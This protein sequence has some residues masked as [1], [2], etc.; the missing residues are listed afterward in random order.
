MH[1]WRRRVVLLAGVLALVP[2]TALLA[3]GNL[4]LFVNLVLPRVISMQPERVRMRWGWAWTWDAHHVEVRDFAMWV[5]GP[6]DQW[7]LHVDHATLDVE[8]LPLL[9]RRFQADD[10]VAQGAVFR[11]RGRV[12]AP[13]VP[14]LPPPTYD[15]ART[16]Q[17]PGMTNPPARD[18]DTLY[19]PPAAPWLVA[20]DDAVVTD[21]RELWLGD[22]RFLGDAEVAGDLILL[23]AASVDL[24]GLHV[25]VNGGDLLVE[26]A[27]VVSDIAADAEVS[28]EGFDPTLSVGADVLRFLD[29]AIRLD[30]HVYDLATMGI[31][32]PS[33]GS[34]GMAGGSGE[35]YAAI[36]LRGGA[37]Q[38]GSRVRARVADAEVSIG[39]WSVV[40]DARLDVVTDSGAEVSLRF[41]EFGVERARDRRTVA[42]GAGFRVDA[43]ADT[44]HLDGAP[45]MMSATVMLPPSDVPDLRLLDG[46]L[47]RDAGVDLRGGRAVVRGVALVTDDGEHVE[48]SVDVDVPEF[49]LAWRGLPVHGALHLGARAAGSLVEGRYQV[50]GTELKLHDVGVGDGPRDWWA[51]LRVRD[52][53]VATGAATYLH[54]TTELRCKD[55]A[56]VFRVA[57]AMAP[58]DDAHDLPKWI[59]QLLTFHDLRGDARLALGQDSIRVE[60]L[61]IRTPKAEVRMRMEQQR[62]ALDAL[63]YVRF[64]RLDVATRLAGDTL[65]AQIVRAAPWFNARLAERGVADSE[66]VPAVDGARKVDSGER[67]GLLISLEKVL[68]RRGSN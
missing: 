48:G 7:Y 52:G 15:P 50:E 53:T 68:K 58:G 9:E 61:A 41:E 30:A 19:G 56:P 49:A 46:F 54:A 43:R 29:G 14:G 8:L 34:I 20:F 55:T 1:P 40:G 45:E 47:P 11:Y 37:V 57:T 35:V 42:R 33:S 66:F 65:T 31:F 2:T 62:D 25:H 59:E 5:Q 17:I 13:P 23:P 36:G 63:L 64:G 60:H 21:V 26:G 39:A 38:P 32:L 22:G 10:L 27:P 12:D 67:P 28:L 18:P 24:S 51:A 4:N 44:L 6:L 16:A 3:L